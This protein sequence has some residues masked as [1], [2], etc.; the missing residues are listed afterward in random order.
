M[1]W[2]LQ[3]APD[4]SD[5]QFEQW[6]K[7]LEDRAGICLSDQQRVFFANASDYAYA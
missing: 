3:A 7:L 6:S 5:R 4:L 1:I 2:S